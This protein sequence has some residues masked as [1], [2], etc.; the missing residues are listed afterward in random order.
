MPNKT[1][2]AW[3]DFSSQL[4]RYRDAAGK[5]VWSCAKTSPGCQHCYAEQLAHRYGRGGPFTEATVRTV[6]P[7]FAEEEA[8]KILRSKVITGKRVFVGDM[9]DCFG[10]WVPDELLDRMF[11]VFALRPDVTFQVLTKRA[12]RMAAYFATYR[13]SGLFP[14]LATRFRDMPDGGTLISPLPNVW[15]GVSVEDQQRANERI[16]HLLRT[17]AAVRF[18]SVEPLLGAV[19]L[20]G[21]WTGGPVESR[22][23]GGVSEPRIHWAIVGGESGPGHRPCEVAWIES[24]A[25][26]CRAA[27]VPVFIKQASGR[28]PGLRGQLSDAVWALKQFP[29]AT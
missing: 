16:P 12:E 22:Q 4:I 25:D 21:R 1:S 14:T 29:E 7:Y 27:G 19:D 6:T 18:L 15:L 8:A 5:D 9:T 10:A 28:G 24:V 3:T 20:Y 23:P 26:Q 11:A 17:P 2:I 13:P